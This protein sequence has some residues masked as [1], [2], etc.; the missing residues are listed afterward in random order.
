MLMQVVLCV[1]LA[2]SV[3]LAWWVQ[4]S[5]AVALRVN[6]GPPVHFRNPVLDL[7]LRLPDGWNIKSEALR[8]HAE[9]AATE[10]TPSFGD[11]RTLH[12]L[13]EHMTGDE[14]PTAMDVAS[15]HMDEQ[16]L[17]GPAVPVTL[18]G[19]PGLLLEYDR[20]EEKL[21]PPVYMAVAVL[22]NRQAE[23]IV[24]LFGVQS[25]APA[26]RELV[27]NVVASIAPFD[28]EHPI[29]LLKA[30]PN[31][32]LRGKFHPGEEDPSTDDSNPDGGD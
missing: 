6:L 16:S 30:G 24:E 22:P 9:L 29:P 25:F 7:T 28:P 15:A 20:L 3:A 31:Q 32:V 17:S 4:H 27:R 18:L 11:K 1:A 5:R 26:D 2:G 10:V 8:T 19:E 12:L 14:K 21:L 13:I 23:V